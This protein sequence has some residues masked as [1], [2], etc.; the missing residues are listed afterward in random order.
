M[1]KQ[2]TLIPAMAALVAACATAVAGAG[3]AEAQTPAETELPEL[4]VT[5][6]RV[7]MPADRI[8]SSV[9][10]ITAADIEERQ[11]AFVGEA[12]RGVPGVAVSR[13]GGFGHLTQARI[14]GAEGNHTLVLI[15]GMEVNDIGFDSEFDF[16]NLLTDGIER[17]EVLRGPQST[18]W[19]GDAMGGV[20]N[21]IT[22]RGE[23][24]PSGTAYL[25]GGSFSSARASA[26]LAGSA[27]AAGYSLTASRYRTHGVSLANEANGNPETDGYRNT[28]VLT[29]LGVDVRDWLSVEG[30]G[31][32]RDSNLE[33]DPQTFDVTTLLSNPP[34][35]GDT[36]SEGIER[37][38]LIRA[39][40]DLLAGR[41]TAVLT[42]QS[43]ETD[44]RNTVDGATSFDSE[45][46]KRKLDLLGNYAWNPRNTLVF[47]IETEEEQIETTYQ[48]RS[49]V[50]SQA[51]FVQYLLTPMDGLDLS[52]GA[53]R[54][55]HQSFGGEDT[56][57]GTASYLLA[58][59]RTRF[60]A[61][62]GTGFK[63]PTLGEL[64]GFVGNPD[65]QPETNRG[66]DA[67]LVQEL[68][69]GRATVEI[70]WF[71]NRIE[72]L[73]VFTPAGLINLGAV[74][75]QGIEVGIAVAPTPALD[76]SLSYTYTDATDEST[77][78]QRVRNPRHRLG[79]AAA[80]RFA[81]GFKSTLSVQHVGERYDLDF[82]R[83]A[84]ERQ[85]TLGGY[86]TVDLTLAY[87]IGDRYEL[88]GRVENLLD[89]DYEEIVD[90]GVPGRAGFV[91]L[92]ARF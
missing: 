50:E 8:G 2:R 51:Y 16:G 1:V 67:G 46:R 45:G 79:L 37:Q 55:E 36:E 32:F 72:N 73:I 12:L 20:V 76:L 44:R 41:L 28:S 52:A 83:P 11:E 90:Y 5:A 87:R 17:I 49:D 3:A 4:V 18:L 54:D 61:S 21:I 71:D 26:S 6:T 10:V 92:R 14:R 86:T 19:G 40:A 60:K 30:V 77:G 13:T 78:R 63:A 81:P 88:Y 80:W 82:S 38:A 43:S 27:G 48:P 35:D 69:G 84:A 34:A 23:G 25:E 58:A 31:R 29:R 9:A 57:R 59:T 15:D 56:F 68:A 42:A 66:W 62:Y 85:V 53:R 39:T 47:G 91:G 89:E 22:R 7:P 24:P 70:G 75:A 65:L 64:F 74:D 33:T